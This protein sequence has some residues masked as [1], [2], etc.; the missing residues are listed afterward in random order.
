MYKE[1]THLGFWCKVNECGDCFT[2]NGKQE[3]VR[4][5]WRYNSDGYPVVSACRLDN[6]GKKIYRSLHVHILVAKAFVDGWF[7]G[8]EVNHKDFNRA[9]PFAGNLEW[10]THKKNVEYSRKA[11]RYPSFIGETN[12]NFGNNALR[13]KYSKDKRLAQEKQSRPRGKNGKAK[14]CRLIW[15]LDWA[16]P[17]NF[18][19]QRDAVD[20]LIGAG[21]VDEA[22]N[23]ESIIKNLKRSEGYHGWFLEQI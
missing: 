12:P 2:K 5:E 1:T 23:K 11:N 20:W 19:C 17:K 21:I 4:R 9:N 15:T 16:T 10:T 22:L 6:N 7:E 8:A 13:E 14:K 3:I 18:N